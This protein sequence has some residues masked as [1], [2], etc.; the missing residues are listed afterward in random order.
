M[1]M[2]RRKRQTVKLTKTRVED[3][4]P[5]AEDYYVWDA[6]LPGF[7]VRVYPTGT[8]MY[9]VKVGLGRRG[10]SRKMVIG[11]HGVEWLPDPVSGEGRTLTVELARSIALERRTQAE[12]GRD[13][14]QERQAL[15]DIPTL[16]EFVEEKYLPWKRVKRSAGTVTHNEGLLVAIYQRLGSR[17]MDQISVG[18]IETLHVS[19][20]D[21]PT[22]ANHCVRLLSHVFNMA[23]LWGALPAGN[24]NPAGSVDKYAE[25]PVERRLSDAELARAGD[26][27]KVAE[28]QKRTKRVDRNAKQPVVSLTAIAILRLLVF[29]GARPSEICH[30]EDGELD[31]Q[32]K[33]IVKRGWKTRG[34]TRVP[35]VRVL[36]LSE[37]A[38]LVLADQLE[39]RP[40]KRKPWVFP[41]HE[42][43]KPF[44]VSG[45]DGAWE[46]LRR[47]AKLP[48][49][50]VSDLGRH[51]FASVGLDA[52]YSLATIGRILGH[53][54][55]RTTARYAHLGKS[56]AS[57]AVDK[58]SARI[59][60]A[61]ARK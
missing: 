15:R 25:Q 21:T 19:L 38:L 40:A 24:E 54:Q 10:R 9:V 42:Y 16:R 51:N 31:L 5:E 8:R 59:A 45:L 49:V 55:D 44:S 39:R 18:D 30:L 26:A 14:A 61:M 43:G 37:E 50:R 32:R 56:A 12:H 33:L 13:P 2:R 3:A 46:T 58:I 36:P 28:E 53:T 22:K 4:K 41:G 35:T 23:R 52:G 48:D 17:R 47:Y 6:L 20:E 60:A 34:R 7:G 27:M 1:L 29:T 57:T 11:E